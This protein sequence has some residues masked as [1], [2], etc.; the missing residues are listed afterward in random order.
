MTFLSHDFPSR[1]TDIAPR[2]SAKFSPPTAK[3]RARS[4]C[5]Y[6]TGT[7]RDAAAR[8]KENS[9]TANSAVELWVQKSHVASIFVRSV[10]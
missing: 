9:A 2:L 4:D 5:R 3:I 8:F 7:T 6:E 1:L 10:D